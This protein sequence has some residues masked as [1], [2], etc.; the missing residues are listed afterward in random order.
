[1]LFLP[2]TGNVVPPV[3]VLVIL[4]VL[5]YTNRS[6]KYEISDTPIILKS[7]FLSE[8]LIQTDEK[9][10]Q[11]HCDNENLIQSMVCKI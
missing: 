2:S 8:K 10:I 4:G 1:M 6:H 11:C 9:L 5:K 3:R 7:A